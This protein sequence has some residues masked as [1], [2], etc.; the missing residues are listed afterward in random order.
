VL[1]GWDP[2]AIAR[3]IVERRQDKDVIDAWARQVR[4]PDEFRW[5]L[6]P[7]HNRLD[8]VG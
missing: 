1:D 5:N 3:R 7:E 6:L 8:P 4:P 2:D